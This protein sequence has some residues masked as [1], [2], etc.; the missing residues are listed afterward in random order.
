MY[1]SLARKATLAILS[2]FI[3]I[4]ATPNEKNLDSVL[5]QAM[6]TELNR[7][8]NLSIPK[9]SKPFFIS[10]TVQDQKSLNIQA[11]LGGILYSS[12]QPYRDYSI[13][14][15]TG[16]YKQT[17]E[18]YSGGASVISG[19]LNIDTSCTNSRRVLW[20][21][22]D[23][24]Y[25]NAAEELA[26]KQS[27]IKQRN[28]PEDEKD[29]FDFSQEKPVQIEIESNDRL[30]NKNHWESILRE[31]SAIFKDYPEVTSSGAF[32]SVGISNIY[33]INSEGSHVKQPSTYAEL[34]VS[35][36]LTMP[37]GEKISNSI[38]YLEKYADSLPKLDA[39]KMETKK[40]A[41]ELIAVSKAPK[42]NES[43]SGPVLFEGEAL[44]DILIQNLY[45]GTNSLFAYRGTATGT[46]PKTLIDK[47]NRKIIANNLTVK[48]VPSLQN[49]QGK[50]L[51]GYTPI[52]MEGVIPD[53]STLLVENGM[54]RKL[55]NDRIP[56]RT[57]PNSTGNSRLTYR[58]NGLGTT[59]APSVIKIE[60][61]D[62]VSHVDLKN[63]LI[64]MAKEEG[65]EYTYIIRELSSYSRPFL[66][67]RVNVADGSEELVQASELSGVTLS[68]LKRIPAISN[69]EK[70]ENLS[71]SGAPISI[72]YPDA[73]IIEDIDI[74]KERESSKTKAPIVDNPVK[75]AKEKNKAKK[76]K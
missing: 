38:N 70:T 13:R 35:A 62:G 73:M 39:L 10:Y 24:L 58:G 30:P 21:G 27:A 8:M 17:N 3:G 42:H 9:L 69:Q 66:I 14:L 25:K 23:A 52:D 41:D 19:S 47:V 29:L 49:Y 20:L 4:S 31:V 59:A 75:A 18:L 57:S 37:D 6:Q 26:Q 61:R 32:F 12:E 55:L 72:I 22:T 50:L 7:S 53:S 56:A 36:V 46:R 48:D 51:V 44:A 2:L 64:E 65:F 34:S 1:N 15:L 60:G 71:F 16:N 28:L 5:F 68:K 40:M 63:K 11:T 74:D 54:L 45:S 67:Y 76:K 33:F 43:Y